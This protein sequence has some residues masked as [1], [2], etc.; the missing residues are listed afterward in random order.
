MT[1]IIKHTLASAKDRKPTILNTQLKRLVDTTG[2][3]SISLF[4]PDYSHVITYA[5][6][7]GGLTWYGDKSLPEEAPQP[8]I[9]NP[10]DLEVKV[11]KPILRHELSPIRVWALERNLIQTG[12]AKTQYIKLMEEAGELAQSILKQNEKEFVDALGDMVVVLTNLAAIKGYNLEECINMAYN[13]IKD[14]KG[15]MVNN[16]FVKNEK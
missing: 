8:L 16:T 15:S 13:T 2:K 6:S 3:E 11:F 5:P 12:D 10:V 14:R 7:R 1:M 4:Y 9:G